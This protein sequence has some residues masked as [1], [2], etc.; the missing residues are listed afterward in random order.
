VKGAQGA[1]EN[2][3]L[4]DY[5]A[6]RWYRAP[7]ILLGSTSYTKAVDMWALGCI[8]AEMFIG[9]PLLQGKSTIDQLQESLLLTGLPDD[10]TLKVKMGCDKFG[11][12]LIGK[13][14][15]S[16]VQFAPASDEHRRAALA[17]RMPMCEE[18]IVDFVCKA[19]DI[20][21]ANRISVDVSPA[22]RDGARDA[23][24]H[25]WLKPFVKENEWDLDRWELCADDSLN[26]DDD[27]KREVS[28]YRDQLYQHLR[29]LRKDAPG[30]LAYF[31]AVRAGARLAGGAKS[32]QRR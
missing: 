2:G 6:T 8:V 3:A 1:A 7:E 9:K 28:Q 14:K 25:P 16:G 5:V 18:G 15:A 11:P 23:L 30:R 24:A 10:D 12:D 21:P 31:G 20:N 29:E 32:S 22:E 19:L 4:T 26:I 17:K 27:E 13:M